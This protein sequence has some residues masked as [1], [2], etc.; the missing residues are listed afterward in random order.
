MI[1]TTMSKI[2]QRTQIT[3]S[4]PWQP[5]TEELWTVS[6]VTAGGY[7]NLPWGLCTDVN[8]FKYSLHKHTR[9]HDMSA[10]VCRTHFVLEKI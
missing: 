6:L 3:K 9:M 2:T 7:F 5:S 8:M 4:D 1:F 10:Q